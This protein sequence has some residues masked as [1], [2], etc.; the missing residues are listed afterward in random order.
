MSRKQRALLFVSYL[1]SH[2]VHVSFLVTLT[3]SLCL[4]AAYQVLHRE[5]HADIQYALTL[6]HA[7]FNTRELD[8]A[9]NCC[10]I[11]T[12]LPISFC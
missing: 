4:G 7:D 2:D 3:L 10:V 12:R 6:R 9:C 11:L 5:D 1:W 8:P